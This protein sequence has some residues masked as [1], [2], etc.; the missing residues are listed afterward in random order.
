MQ[1]GMSKQRS[2]RSQLWLAG[3]RCSCALSIGHLSKRVSCSDDLW[4]FNF[5][6]IIEIRFVSTTRELVARLHHN[7]PRTRYTVAINHHSVFLLM[8][9]LA[10]V[11]LF[12][13]FINISF[14]THTSFY[15]LIHL[16]TSGIFGLL[17][18]SRIV[19]AKQ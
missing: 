18:F 8:L 1:L 10:S 17:A 19:L 6:S 14:I 12:Y 5:F 13:I 9:L 4:C 7:Q 11:F 16:S 15:R 3:A 2:D